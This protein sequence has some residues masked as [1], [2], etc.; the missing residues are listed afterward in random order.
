MT[1]S[2]ISRD[3]TRI[4]P[5]RDPETRESVAVCQQ[6]RSYTK[7]GTESLPLSYRHTHSHAVT[8]K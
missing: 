7:M 5:D 3:R 2:G 6:N 1:N 8:E 4:L